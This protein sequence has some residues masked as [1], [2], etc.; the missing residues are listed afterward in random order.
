MSVDNLEDLEKRLLSPL[1][2]L[3]HDPPPFPEGTDSSHPFKG[4]ET[5]A[6]ERLQY[7]IKSDNM[8]TYKDTRNGLSGLDFST[9]LSG[10]LAIGCLSARQI[11][12][13]LVAF[14]DGTNS[15]YEEGKGY[16][17]GENNGTGA[18]RFE[19]LWRDYM[20]LCTM[21]FGSHLFKLEGFRQDP[22]YNSKWLFA[23]E[24]LA[25]KD[26]NPPPEKVATMLKRFLEGTTG[27][28]FIDAAQRELY[29][30]GYTS[31]RARQNVASFLTKHLGLDWRYGAEWY[32]S[33]LVDY[34]VSS[35]WA[36]W[37]YVA[38]VGNDPRGDARIF[39][40]VKQAFDYDS[41]AEFVKMWLPELRVF[42]RPE[43][44][45]QAWT[46][47]KAL[48]QEKGLAD[49]QMAIDPLKRVNFIVDRR[50]GR[51]VR[52]MSGRSRG[53]GGGGSRS[54]GGDRGGDRG[55]R[56]GGRGD[57]SG[58]G[59]PSDRGRG[60]RGGP[61]GRGGRG[62]PTGRGAFRG[63]SRGNGRGGAPSMRGTRGG[64]NEGTTF[65]PRIGARRQSDDTPVI[66]GSSGD[67]E[68]YGSATT[69]TSGSTTNNQDFE[70]DSQTVG[71]DQS[72]RDIQGDQGV[73]NGKNEV[74]NTD[75]DDQSA[76]DGMKNGNG[77]NGEVDQNGTS[78]QTNQNGTESKKHPSPVIVSS[79]GPRPLNTNAQPAGRG[80]KNSNPGYGQQTA[81]GTKRNGFPQHPPIGPVQQENQGPQAY[82]MTPM[83]NP[84][85]PM[86]SPPG[87]APMYNGLPYAPAAPHQPSHHPYPGGYAGNGPVGPG[88]PMMMNQPYVQWPQPYHHPEHPQSH[89]PHGPTPMGYQHPQAY[90]GPPQGHYDPS[91]HMQGPVSYGSP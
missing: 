51:T 69:A 75:K 34:D 13:E 54:Q 44:A 82:G 4:G 60:G 26:Q 83:Y 38:G 57:A 81:M 52:K 16:G 70:K 63:A 22:D 36:N 61:P 80:G 90:Q 12:H 17:Q 32:E 6:W 41:N 64:R 53:Q 27:M 43:N 21:K 23:D 31:N 1:T 72:N 19:L 45:F 84:N 11:H 37:Q 7:L 3:L 5:E 46:A 25:S 40:P 2:E 10:Y 49:N 30:T 89:H 78:G 39:N 55:G 87:P 62:G 91:M 88:S 67:A 79:G 35:N 50:P 47:N 48:L 29:L 66:G 15:E 65:A 58:R 56:G 24:V 59:G 18:I 71:N 73:Q 76:T 33:M 68:E 85:Y 74:E 86:G 77:Q 9:K 8:S 42:N 14:E 20:R 28:G